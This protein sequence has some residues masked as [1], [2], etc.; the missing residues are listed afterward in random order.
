MQQISL[1]PQQIDAFDAIMKWHKTKQKR[2][3]LSG[4]AGTGKTT[5]ARKL[6]DELGAVMFLAYTGKAV[7]VLREKGISRF[8]TI[9]SLIY[10]PIKRN[11]RLEFILKDIS[12]IGDYKLV[13]VDEYSMLS[14]ELMQDLESLVGKVLYLGDNF[15]LPPVKGSN[16]LK[17]DFQLTEVHRQALESNII[18]IASDIRQGILPDY[19]DHDD[20][21]FNRKKT[22]NKEIFLSADQLLVGRNIT[23]R[24]WIDRYRNHKELPEFTI[25]KGEKIICLKNNQK[26]S[27]FNGMIGEIESDLHLEQGR[28]FDQIKFD[29]KE[30]IDIWIG[31]FA[32][33]DPIKH[34]VDMMREIN[35]FD[36]GY[37]ITVHKSQGSEF[38]TIVL[39]NEPIGRS[40]LEQWRWLYTGITRARKKV[41]LID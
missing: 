19:C 17:P 4:Y 29:G 34:K 28:F 16:A 7:N 30:N 38:D 2:F 20:F 37:A 8:S 15:Q 9:H 22:L 1:S 5:L 36:F 41:Y 11:G 39:N 6:E 31:D 32:G 10:K 21:Y 25:Q 27:I 35:R 3:V 12:E 26:L 40:N 33:L 24:D 23:R 18:R 14:N 13:I